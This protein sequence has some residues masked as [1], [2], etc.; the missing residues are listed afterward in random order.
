MTTPAEDPAHGAHLVGS[1]PLASAETVFETVAA[2]L[3][4]RVL[5]RVRAAEARRPGAG[6][7]PLSG[8][9][10]HTAGAHQRVRGAGAPGG[11]GAG[12]RDA[13]ARGAGARPAGSA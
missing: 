10:A 8:V 2:Q 1:V 9:P 12:V 4:D 3:G 11:A 6:G 13:P 7:L 5:S